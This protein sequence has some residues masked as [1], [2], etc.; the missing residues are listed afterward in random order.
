MPPIIISAL[1]MRVSK[2]ESLQG[3]AQAFIFVLL[4]CGFTFFPE[5]N[6]GDTKKTAIMAYDDSLYVV[7]EDWRRKRK[8]GIISLG[9]E[10]SFYRYIASQ[11]LSVVE[12]VQEK[13][14]EVRIILSGGKT[15]IGINGQI[16]SLAGDR[17]IR[18]EH[19]LIFF[20]DERC[21]PPDHPDSN[22]AMIRETLLHRLDIPRG[23][24][25]R[26][27]GELGPEEAA[28]AYE[29]SI[30]SVFKDGV[31]PDFDLILLGMGTD[32][33]TASL[34]PGSIS[35][36][37]T[38]RYAVPGGKGPEGHDRVTLTYPLLN[39]GRKIWIMATGGKKQDALRKLL[40]G[41]FNPGECPAQG[42]C[43]AHG[44]LLYILGEG[45]S[46]E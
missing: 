34:F 33:H 43:P 39:R 42:I 4:R 16:V 13:R 35:I 37:E 32:G 25:F 26:F 40:Y 23:N 11:F 44:E 30:V 22:Y 7:Q 19:V 46:D 2:T 29:R 15:P 12:S 21:V 27:F 8:P 20:S 5:N 1:F 24:I 10:A 17:D 3:Q 28:Q 9:D 45:L 38:K 14:G 41:P 36:R 31:S 18:W 6:Q